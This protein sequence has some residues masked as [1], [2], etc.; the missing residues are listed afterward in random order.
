MAKGF[1]AK[2]SNSPIPQ[3]PLYNLIEDT[4]SG[5]V[6]IEENLTKAQARAKIEEL[7]NDGVNPQR[8]KIQRVS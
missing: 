8:I 2:S 7:A 6:V 1:T 4:T 3:E 5:D